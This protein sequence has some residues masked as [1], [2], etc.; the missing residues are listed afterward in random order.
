MER[1]AVLRSKALSFE[2]NCSIGFRSGLYGGRES[3]VGTACFDS[4][5]DAG[6]F[7][8]LTLSML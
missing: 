4:F 8:T 5:A 2:K 1:A 6:N 3:R 7:W